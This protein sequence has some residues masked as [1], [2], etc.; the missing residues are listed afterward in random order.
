MILKFLINYYLLVLLAA[1]VPKPQGK[2]ALS[3]PFL[4]HSPEN[5]YLTL[6]GSPHLDFILTYAGK[7]GSLKV[8][9]YK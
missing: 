5:V 4:D 2:G 1:K 6:R 3:A 8:C 7:T 9:A